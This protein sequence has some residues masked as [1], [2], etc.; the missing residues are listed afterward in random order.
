LRKVP[1]NVAGEITTK[2]DISTNIINKKPNH[3]I[4]PK[5]TVKNKFIAGESLFL[6]KHAEENALIKYQSTIGVK[7][8]KRISP[9]KLHILVVRIN[10]NNQ[11]TN[12]KPC[13]HCVEVIKSFGIRKVTYST[14]D[15]LVT[16]LLREM[17]TISS[18]GYRSFGKKLEMINSVI[19]DKSGIG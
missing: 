6:S 14:N 4:N 5:T 12:S 7:G 2:Q 8:R 18:S 17:V 13:S 19:F 16:E 15:G 11:I 10:A 1:I 3:V 9:R